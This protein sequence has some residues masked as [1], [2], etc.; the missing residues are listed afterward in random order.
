[1]AIRAS[2]TADFR[3]RYREID[4]LLV[5]DIHFIIG[6]EST[7]EEFFHTFNWLYDNG[8]QIVL[9]SD[10]APN[11]MRILDQRLRSR[12]WWG[13]TAD[14]QPPDFDTRVEILRRKAMLRTRSLPDEVL[15]FLA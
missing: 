7:Q 1:S 14:I 6:K 12:F 9:S 13:L 4:V 3:Q 5:D 10:R 8:K 2:N 15:A 11:E